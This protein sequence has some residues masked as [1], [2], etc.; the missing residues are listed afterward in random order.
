MTDHEHRFQPFA[1]FHRAP[2]GPWP[3]HTHVVVLTC[4]DPD[5][6]VAELFPPTNFALCTSEFRTTL[7]ALMHV[8]GYD[9]PGGPAG[10][11]REWRTSHFLGGEPENS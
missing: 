3:E 2:T 7:W 1:T 4:T 5:C 10:A 8:A 11:P 6:R 9:L